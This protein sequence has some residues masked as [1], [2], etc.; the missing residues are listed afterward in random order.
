MIGSSGKLWSTKPLH[1]WFGCVQTFDENILQA[2]PQT[3]HGELVEAHK[4]PAH[5]C[6]T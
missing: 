3:F 6:T 2:G 4:F 5:S 1:D